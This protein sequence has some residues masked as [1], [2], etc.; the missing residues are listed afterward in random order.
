MFHLLMSLV[1]APAVFGQGDAVNQ[2]YADRLA[3]FNRYLDARAR[4]A[5]SAAE[6]KAVDKE[7]AACKRRLDAARAG[8]TGLSAEDKAFWNGL[9][10][11]LQAVLNLWAQST[12][13]DAEEQKRTGDA[14]QAA[15]DAALRCYEAQMRFVMA[16]LGQ[17]GRASCRERV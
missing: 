8:Y 15:Y 2:F 1:L 4:T 16:Q 3:E 12:D 11:E 17:I 7:R 13:A 14:A 10:S 9:Q 6:K 5:R